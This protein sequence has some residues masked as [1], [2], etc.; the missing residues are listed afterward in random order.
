M[1]W[2]SSMNFSSQLQP[3][4]K[5]KRPHIKGLNVVKNQ[6]QCM[7]KSRLGYSSL[8]KMI[9]VRKYSSIHIENRIA[10]KNLFI[11]H[12]PTIIC[13]MILHKA[14]ASI[15]CT[16]YR[17]IMNF[18][19][20][21]KSIC[22]VRRSFEALMNFVSQFI[23]LTYPVNWRVHTNSQIADGLPLDFLNIYS[24]VRSI[25]TCLHFRVFVS[26]QYLRQ[27]I[28]YHVR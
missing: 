7:Y 27:T 20:I 1:F 5:R 23:Q 12:R 16:E 15:V 19:L 2:A 26:A 21:K 10:R 13:A 9:F 17:K 24:N 4:T 8:S 28:A 11:T 18:V 6:Y 22:N 25:W 3:A 14:Q